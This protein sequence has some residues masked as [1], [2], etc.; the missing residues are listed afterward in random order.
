MGGLSDILGQQIIIEM[1]PHDQAWE[2]YAGTLA[3][4]FNEGRQ[5]YLTNYAKYV[6]KRNGS[7]V[8]KI[9]A[10]TGDVIVLFWANI[11]CLKLNP[12]TTSKVNENGDKRNPKKN[13]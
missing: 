10:E 9:L 4:A 7:G 11:K 1:I 2:E 12:K 5:F 13:K 3:F 6:C 8:K